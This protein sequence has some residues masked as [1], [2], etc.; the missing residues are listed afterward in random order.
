MLFMKFEPLK[1]VKRNILLDTDI[2]PDCDDV[3]A[4]VLLHHLAKKYDIS[5]SA[6]C[7]CTSN[8]YG[9][10]AIDVIN[11][12][13][14]APEIPLGI[15]E[16]SDFWDG[17]DTKC[18]NRLLSE[19]FHTK[20]QP[21][22]PKHPNSAVELYKRILEKAEDDSILFIT[23]GMLN[24][25]AELAEAAVDLLNRKVYAFVTMAGREN[26]KQKEFNVNCDGISFRK[27]TEVIQKPIFFSPFETGAGV[28]SGF[29]EKGEW[30]TE[31][32]P[33]FLAYREY[34][35]AMRPKK[36]YL[37]ASYDLTAVHFAF[38]GEG[39]YYKLSESG[40][41]LCEADTNETI[42]Q[43]GSGKDFCIERNC[44]EEEL[45][46]YFSRILRNA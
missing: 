26:E 32:N 19:K 8:P 6:I 7:N 18:Y 33:V 46:A 39:D 27:F 23:I 41:M 43:T 16:R 3:G 42:F 25:I 20:Y 1:R 24:N 17:A 45:G 9:C 22:G 10:G 29:A 36:T 34:L 11:R 2:G 5:I 40:K 31:N 38:E 12:Y 35:N 44:T 28:M 37:N 13:C 14:G 30:N 4:L 15:T 21:V